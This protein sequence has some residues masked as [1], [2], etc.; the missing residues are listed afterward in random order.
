MAMN[1]ISQLFNNMNI[2]NWINLFSVIA[3]WVTILLLL[4]E[5]SEKNKPQLQISVE[6]I[7]SSLACVVIRNTGIVP[8]ELLNL[9]FDKEFINQL[10]QEKTR[11]L[12]NKG[13]KDIV[14]FPDKS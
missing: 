13:I 5:K 8:V 14:L 4:H 6:L 9:Q 3:V 2:G 10:P 1:Y 12:I 11:I 7:R